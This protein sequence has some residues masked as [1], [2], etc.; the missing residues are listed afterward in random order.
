MTRTVLVTGAAGF[1][2]SHACEALKAQGDL[3]IGFDNFNDYY[4]VA[5]KRANAKVLEIAG[6]EIVEGDIRNAD[7]LEQ[8]FRKLEVS[9][10]TSAAAIAIRLMSKD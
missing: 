6:I 2:G 1:I 8:V 9:N 4:D 5:Q 3:V 10:R 7:H